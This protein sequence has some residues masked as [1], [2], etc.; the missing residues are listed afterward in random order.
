MS[1]IPNI[2]HLQQHGTTKQLIVN[3]KPFL[4]L[5]GELQNSSFSSAE[6]MSE[7]WPKMVATNIN[8]VLGAVTWEMIEP[9]EGRFDFKEFDKVV[10]DARK[11]GIHLVLLWFGSF[12]N[13]ASHVYQIWRRALMKSR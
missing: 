8:T 9:G 10:L 13:G 12:K 6:Y 4:M 11:Y 2:P 5:G 1:P 3:G 7:V